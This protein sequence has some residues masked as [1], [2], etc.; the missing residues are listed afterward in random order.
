[1]DASY[2]DK[3]S[4]QRLYSLTPIFRCWRVKNWSTLASTISNKIYRSKKASKRS[5]HIFGGA[6]S[7]Q[8]HSHD[9]YQSMTISR[10]PKVSNSTASISEACITLKILWRWSIKSYGSSP[11]YDPV[12]SVRAHFDR[13]YGTRTSWPLRRPNIFLCSRLSLCRHYLCQ[14]VLNTP[15]IL[16]KWNCMRYQSCC[17]YRDLLK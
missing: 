11:V 1:M 17:I 4:N 7:P 5:F 14:W 9:L 2:L 8:D 15:D 10:D 12:N 16:I 13:L 3:K 6:L